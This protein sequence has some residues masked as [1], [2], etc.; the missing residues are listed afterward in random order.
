M[1]FD[2]L[3]LLVYHPIGTKLKKQSRRYFK[4]PNDMDN[5]FSMVIV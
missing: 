3:T 2:G 5:G 1:L 4:D